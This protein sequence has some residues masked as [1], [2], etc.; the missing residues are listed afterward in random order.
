LEVPTRW[1]FCQTY[2]FERMQGP[3]GLQAGRRQLFEPD[4]ERETVRCVF[5]AAASLRDRAVLQ[6]ASP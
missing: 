6:P 2:A 5:G 1:Q 3:G 4:Q